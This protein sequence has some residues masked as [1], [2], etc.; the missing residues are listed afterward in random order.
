MSFHC[1]NEKREPSETKHVFTQE[2]INLVEKSIKE[3]EDEIELISL[4]KCILE[5]GFIDS[6]LNILFEPITSFYHSEERAVRIY[7]P[8]STLKNRAFSGFAINIGKIFKSLS[9][10]DEINE[11]HLFYTK[12]LENIEYIRSKT[13][14]IEIKH[15]E[16]DRYGYPDELFNPSSTY[17]LK[18]MMD[19]L[20]EGI[21]EYRFDK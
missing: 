11:E 15:L 8:I 17:S 18:G 10:I 4:Y 1:D 19:S 12:R 3:E 2:Y 7:E 14:I 5:N 9:T 13:R 6:Y 20:K 21:I 16:E